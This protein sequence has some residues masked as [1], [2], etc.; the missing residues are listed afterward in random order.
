MT[1][2]IVIL[3]IQLVHEIPFPATG[4]IASHSKR[5]LAAIHHTKSPSLVL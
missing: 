3:A 4:I 1:F 5:D 2:H